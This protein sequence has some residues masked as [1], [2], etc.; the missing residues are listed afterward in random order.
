MLSF[1]PHSRTVWIDHFPGTTPTTTFTSIEYTSKQTLSDTNV[2]VLNCLFN[3]C[4]STGYGGAFYCTSSVTK[5]LVESTSFFSCNTSSTKGGAVY[6][7]NKESGECVLYKVCASDCC[8][9]SGLN[10]LFADIYA[11]NTASGKNYVIY[12]S[13]ARCINEKIGSWHTLRLNYGNNYCSSVNSSMNKCGW[14]PGISCEPTADS[15]SVTCLVVYS[16]FVDNNATQARVICF[17]RS[18][19]NYEMKWCN[20]LRNSQ[21]SLSTNGL[22]DIYGS[23]IIENSCIIEN[24]ADYIFYSSTSITYTISNCTLDKTT[25][26][27][28]LTTRNTV[29]KS[30]ILT[31]N[32]M[33]TQNCHADH[34][35][36]D[37]LTPIKIIVTC[38]ILSCPS[39]LR[40]FITLIFS[41]M[42]N[43]I[44]PYPS[45]DI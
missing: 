26:N 30:F 35:T 32:H 18:S 16:T 36:V 41:F 19:A 21:I 38:R 27:G 42:F 7:Y 40:D 22:I 39:H 37:T 31:L 25:N 8:S 17:G 28:Y 3:K 33:F 23:T 12:S 14:R 11:K 13:I 43:F 6:F 24:V 10:G 20:I 45:A 34:S 5:L 2:Y 29:T 15:S 44:N 9:E 1:T 4:T